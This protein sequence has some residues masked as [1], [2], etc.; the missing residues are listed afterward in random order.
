MPRTSLR[1]YSLPSLAFR[2]RFRPVPSK[3][4]KLFNCTRI[5]PRASPCLGLTDDEAQNKISKKKQTHQARQ[6]RRQRR[7]RRLLHSH[8]ASLPPL[9]AAVRPLT[10]WRP[11]PWGASGRCGPSKPVWSFLKRKRFLSF[12]CR[13]SK[14]RGRRQP[15]GGTKLLLTT[16]K[17]NLLL[18]LQPLLHHR[19]THAAVPPLRSPRR[20]RQAPLLFP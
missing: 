19:K 18:F 11:S 17:K 3:Y 20:R 12:R 13:W 4:Q 7:R 16:K 6:R 9:R 5:T 1:R 8:L 15:K 14:H 2:P 10:L